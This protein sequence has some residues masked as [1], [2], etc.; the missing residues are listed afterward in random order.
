MDIGFDR[1]AAP[2]LA[3]G[4]EL[5]INA[6]FGAAS[7]H[8]R[9]G[10]FEQVRVVP[11][12]VAKPNIHALFVSLGHEDYIHRQL[13]PHGSNRHER[14]ISSHL[15]SFRIHRASGHQHFLELALLNDARFKG[16]NF[17]DIGLRHGHGIVLPIDNDGLRRA[18]V[19]LGVHHRISRQSPLGDA[20]I[21]DFRFLTPELIEETLDHLGGFLNAFAAVRNARLPDPLLQPFLH[22]F[23]EVFVDVS[24]DFLEFLTLDLRHV[25][26]GNCV[27]LRTIFMSHHCRRTFRGSPA[28]GAPGRKHDDA[29]QGNRR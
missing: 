20:R 27:A 2:T 14:V 25:D 18:L 15:R 16:R 6:T 24:V 9:V 21:I 8:H 3:A 10:A 1:P 19:A 17:P 5:N 23:V 13:S 11:H 26:M 28:L 4:G 29:D 7:A 12:E 22:V